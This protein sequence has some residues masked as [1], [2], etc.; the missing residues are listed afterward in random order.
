M[1]TTINASGDSIPNY[2]IFKGIRPRRDYTLFCKD[3]ATFGMQKKSWVDSYQF[4]KW[5]NHFLH[6]LIEKGVL[7][8][9][10]RHLL[11]LDGHKAHLFL[12]V[13]QKQKQ[14]EWI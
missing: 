1:L 4:S 11:V 6:I 7:S 14:M 5:M 9:I 13:P 8:T 2:Y 12:E 10:R 3:N